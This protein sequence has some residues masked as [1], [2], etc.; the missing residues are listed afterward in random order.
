MSPL[1]LFQ[2]P[3]DGQKFFPVKFGYEI[4]G[5]F[6]S[7]FSESTTNEETGE[8]ERNNQY[9]RHDGSVSSE[10]YMAGEIAS[11][12]FRVDRMNQFQKFVKKN[13]PSQVDSSAGLHC[14]VSVNSKYAYAR[15]MDV[16]FWNAF[17]TEVWK[18]FKESYIDETISEETYEEFT[19][20][21]RGKSRYCKP[22]FAPN[23][24]VDNVW[25]R[26]EN[27]ED[28]RYTQLNY[29]FGQHGTIECRLFPATTN[30]NEI[31]NII[32][33]F[34]TFIAS[35]LGKIPAY[36]RDNSSDIDIDVTSEQI[37]ETVEICV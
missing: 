34:I 32:S 26:L 25:Y 18:F 13:L 7:D 2:N 20:R 1:P 10:D 8:R 4:E 16:E 23:S 21:F 9:W 27:N 28:G 30:A 37:K 12:V 24:Q 15:L 22:V 36:E 29:P 11:P 33:W 14:H 3:F 6:T 35:Y 19:N 5:G 31:I 17:K